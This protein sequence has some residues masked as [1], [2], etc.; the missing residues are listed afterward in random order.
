M[1]GSHTLL[2]ET[3]MEMEMEMETRK[4]TG[5]STSSRYHLPIPS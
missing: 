2:P 3:E 4:I 1:Q 5:S